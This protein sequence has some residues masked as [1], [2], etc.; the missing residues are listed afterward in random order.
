MLNKLET[1]LTL[2]LTKGNAKKSYGG[3]EV[4]FHAFLTSTMDGGD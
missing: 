2:S 1:K 4:E 3:V